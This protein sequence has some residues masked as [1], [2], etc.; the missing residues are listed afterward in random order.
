MEVGSMSSKLSAPTVGQRIFGP[1]ALGNQ[2]WFGP[3]IYSE[4]TF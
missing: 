4:S 3:V 2:H 1:F